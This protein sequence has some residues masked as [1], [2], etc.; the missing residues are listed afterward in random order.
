MT[1][2]QFDTYLEPKNGGVEAI[3]GVNYTFPPL[4]TTRTS[5]TSFLITTPINSSIQI[6]FQ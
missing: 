5:K 1:N 4:T 2:E 3:M 6:Q